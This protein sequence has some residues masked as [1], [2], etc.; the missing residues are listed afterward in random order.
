MTH[1]L[2]HLPRSPAWGARF[3]A[4]R[5]AAAV[6]RSGRLN[7]QVL[8]A[9]LVVA[10]LVVP[11]LMLAQFHVERRND[12]TLLVKAMR[13]QLTTIGAALTAEIHTGGLAGYAALDDRL[14]ALTPA[15]MRIKVLYRPA[16]GGLNDAFL[17]V[18]TSEEI[19]PL[20]LD[21]ERAELLRAGILDA[22]G[23]GCSDA[24]NALFR[25]GVGSG[26]E[27]LVIGVVPIRAP[28]GC[29]AV[30]ASYVRGG[31]LESAVA[32]PFW[33]VPRVQI[34]LAVYAAMALV[35]TAVLLRIHH[36][37][38]ALRDTASAISINLDE[39]VQFAAVSDVSELDSTAQILDNM[40]AELRRARLEALHA[41]EAKMRYLANVSHELRSPL[42]AIIGFSQ[43]IEKQLFGPI[44]ESRYVEYAGDIQASG[45]YLLE[46]INDILDLSKL[47]A[48][49]FE[50]TIE[51]VDPNAEIRW[52]ARLLAGEARKHG[53]T[54]DVGV[55]EM[56][57]A[58]RGDVR[59]FRSILVNLVTNAI[60]YTPEGGRIALRGS[61]TEAG[62]VAVTVSDNGAGIAP[63]D[64]A[65]VFEPYGRGGD[66]LTAR[67]EG[68]GLGLPLVRHLVELQG[69]RIDFD[70]VVGR[71]TTVTVTLP[72]AGEPAGAAVAAG[73]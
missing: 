13:D 49:R 59:A 34:A 5:A 48:G 28:Q 68:T 14:K 51:T 65:R 39:P 57:P 19:D 53:H 10:F 72:R 29:W 24:G 66:A 69:G 47:E 22:L 61:V 52:T 71:G 58:L 18:A 4:W 40:V 62:D 45:R 26:A 38:T 30:V 16:S 43:V 3:A 73:I 56:L 7:L 17:Y 23:A 33:Q 12:E 27:E 25:L 20:R 9:L 46:M 64:L 70:S 32:R 35:V 8:L 44:G 37:V 11:L 55:P 41:S 60:K 67:R 6:R 1:V 36:T 2:P 42:N 31:I 63:E 50:L 54:L 21:E 15:D